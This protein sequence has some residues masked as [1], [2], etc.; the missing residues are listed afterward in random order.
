MYILYILYNKY[1]YAY[2]PSWGVFGRGV[3]VGESIEKHI[4]FICIYIYQVC[5]T[6]FLTRSMKRQQVGPFNSLC[7]IACFMIASFAS[8]DSNGIVHC[9][10]QCSMHIQ[11]RNRLHRV[12]GQIICIWHGGIVN[13][14]IP[15]WFLKNVQNGYNV[16]PLK[17]VPLRGVEQ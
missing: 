11:S 16:N 17:N 9:C 8:A 3:G 2:S 13:C 12:L 4:V 5:L 15:V 1:L 14:W 10:F 7:L 6:V